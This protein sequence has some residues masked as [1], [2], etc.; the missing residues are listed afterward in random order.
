MLFNA[1]EQIEETFLSIIRTTPKRIEIYVHDS[2]LFLLSAVSLFQIQLN[3][4]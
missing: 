3:F 4:I 2:E 1:Y